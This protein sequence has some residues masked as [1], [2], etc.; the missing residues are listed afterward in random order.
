MTW[1]Y[2]RIRQPLVI[3]RRSRQEEEREPALLRGLQ[4]TERC[5]KERLFPTAPD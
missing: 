2:R 4:E 5:H 3:L 1:G